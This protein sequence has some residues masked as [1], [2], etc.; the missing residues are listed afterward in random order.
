MKY[1]QQK[2]HAIHRLTSESEII[3]TVSGKVEVASFGKGP[4]VLIS[5]GGG[6]GYDMGVW[7]GRLIGEGFLY[8]APSRFG[9]LQSP[10]PESP[11]PEKQADTFT[12]LLD[13]LKIDS[14]HIIGLSSGGPSAL[15][16]AYRHSD[17]CD[18]LIMLSAISRSLP[19]LPLVLRMLY[20]IILR[21]DFIPWF[22]YAV[23]PG[24]VHRSNGVTRKIL[25]QVNEDSEKIQLLNELFQT[26]FPGSLRRKGIMND[27]QQCGN[28]T[29]DFLSKIHLPTLVIH[30]INDPIVPFDLG[31]YSAENIPQARFGVIHD[32]GHFCTVTNL[33][34]VI[35]KIREFLS[36]NNAK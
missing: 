4:P 31:E 21:S 9:Y 13:T 20:P 2:Q 22:I 17:R 30:G 12:I 6:G 32:G 16:F 10:L 35:P 19:P 8:I 3:E 14:I 28:L 27:Q 36:T 11:T 5:H 24:F 34:D 26:T 7:L 23:N 33:D 29:D 18:G 25:D 1:W 15:Q